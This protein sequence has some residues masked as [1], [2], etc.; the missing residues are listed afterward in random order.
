[1][2]V[3]FW[4]LCLTILFPL[5]ASQALTLD[6]VKAA[7]FE[8]MRD[9]HPQSDPAFW[10]NLGPE[11]VPYLEQMYAGSNSPT[12][13]AW[14]LDGLSHYSD[15]SIGPFLQGQ[16]QSSDN[17]VF[18]KKMLFTLIASQG[19]SAFNFV[20]P[21]LKDSDPH[22]RLEVAKGMQRYMTGFPKAASRLK[23]FNEEE[24]ET[25]VKKDLEQAT[26]GP[27]G[28]MKRAGTILSDEVEIK[29]LAEKDWAGD[30]IGV[31]ISAKKTAK[32]T[33]T[34]TRLEK[35]KSWKVVLKVS[36]Q[37]AY[38]LK[39]DGMEVLVYN[40]THLHWIE[41]RNKKDDSVFIG[42]RTP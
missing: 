37:T 2:K 42:Q 13:Q 25:W 33:V 19:D 23:L 4:V 20:E 36:K 21:Y 1:M 15:P 32:G 39:R 41:V 31:W 17:D 28:T 35:E 27:V 40:S 6:Q 18:K 22:V 11:A 14:I 30:W 3:I 29:V 9:R 5:Q 24:K 10:T 7:V 8:K 34:L 38:E 26:Q 12:E 16:I